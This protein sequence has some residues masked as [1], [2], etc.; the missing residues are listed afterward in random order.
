[1]K[2]VLLSGSG[3]FFCVA[4][5]ILLF[6]NHKSCMEKYKASLGNLPITKLITAD[7]DFDQSSSFVNHLNGAPVSHITIT[8]G[9]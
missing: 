5:S 2:L 9:G 4:Q 6:I 3:V 7:F 8:Y 1:M